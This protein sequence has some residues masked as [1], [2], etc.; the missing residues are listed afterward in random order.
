MLWLAITILLWAA[1]AIVA[2]WFFYTPAAQWLD[3]FNEHN[4]AVI[5][6]FF[7]DPPAEVATAKTKR[8]LYVIEAAAFVIG[9][10]V[11]QHPLFGFWA[12]GLTLIGIRYYGKFLR[13]RAAERFDDQLVDVAMAFRNSLKAGLT[14]PQTMQMIASDFTPPAS[15]QFRMCVREIQVGASIEEALQHLVERV[16]NADLRMM[17]GSV[18]IL[19]QTGGNMVETFEG[20]AETLKNRKKVEG[21]IKTLTAQGRYQTLML[22]A[23]PFVMLMILYAM[24]REYVRPLFSTFLGWLLLSVV[25]LLVVTGYIIINKITHIEV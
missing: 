5:G 10:L 23:M 13:Q 2:Y 24:N 1:T 22:C 9:L 16:P 7:N 18:E 12:L 15:D 11:S 3:N 14:L 19:R 8:A 4:A 21:K 20:V 25:V 17:V 6:P